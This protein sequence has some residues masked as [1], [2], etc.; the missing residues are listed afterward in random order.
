MPKIFVMANYLLPKGYFQPLLGRVF[1]AIF[2]L[3]DN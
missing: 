2:K 3:Y 1:G